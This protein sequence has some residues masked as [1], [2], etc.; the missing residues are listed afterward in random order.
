MVLHLDPGNWTFFVMTALA[1]WRLARL[2]RDDA[3]P[4]GLMVAV[5]RVLYHLRLGAVVECV[6]CAAVWIAI[7][8]T[9]VVF[10]PDRRSVLVVLGLAGAMSMLERHLEGQSGNLESDKP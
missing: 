6:H 5:R 3:G 10:E 8:L 7:G 9:V 1:G 4:F 2:L